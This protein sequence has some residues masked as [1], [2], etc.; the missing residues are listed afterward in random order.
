MLN[1]I[2]DVKSKVVSSGFVECCK[3]LEYC[4]CCEDLSEG[5]IVDLV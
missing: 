5:L 1:T 4:P 2:Y 3:S